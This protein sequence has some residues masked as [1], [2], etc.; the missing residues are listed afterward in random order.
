MAPIWPVK[1]GQNKMA[2]EGGGLYFMFLVPPSPKFLDP[3]LQ[4][5]RFSGG[6]L[7]QVSEYQNTSLSLCFLQIFQQVGTINPWKYH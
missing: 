5:H 4:R 6:Y 7:S 2:T 1:I 3:L